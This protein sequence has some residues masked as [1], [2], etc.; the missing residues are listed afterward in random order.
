MELCD[1]KT[2]KLTLVYLNKI[3]QTVLE[4]IIGRMV[5]IIMGSFQTAKD[6]VWDI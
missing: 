6:M 3:C 1:F 5:I 2:A 4:I